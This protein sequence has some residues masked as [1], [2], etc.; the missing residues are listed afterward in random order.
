M[1]QVRI[2][3]ALIAA[4][5]LAILVLQFLTWRAIDAIYVPRPCG[6]VGNSCQVELNRYSI[7]AVGEAVA[8]KISTR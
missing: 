1:M 2:V 6:A 8:R 7:D 5:L 4:I 3:H